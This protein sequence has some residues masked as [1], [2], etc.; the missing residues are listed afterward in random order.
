MPNCF[1]GI[2]S[3]VCA[4]S[5]SEDITIF[6]EH[7]ERNPVGGAYLKSPNPLPSALPPA[8]TA[9]PNVESCPKFQVQVNPLA[10]L[11]T[12]LQRL[13]LL[14][15]PLPHKSPEPELYWYINPVP[16]A[17]SPE[18]LQ[19]PFTPTHH[20]NVSGSQHIIIISPAD[21][22][23]PILILPAWLVPSL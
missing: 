3:S 20:L 16:L 6:P 8:V 14:L 17:G 9:P 15:W 1:W 22:V 5:M 7:V 18:F 4:G 19:V 2:S 11:Q 21:T 10:L 12:L 13:L 23:P